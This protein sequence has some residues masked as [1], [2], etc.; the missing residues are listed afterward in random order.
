[1]KRAHR[2]QGRLLA[3]LLPIFLALAAAAPTA[4]EEVVQ[5]APADRADW[6]P[7]NLFGF[8]RPGH[9]Y[10]ERFIRVRTV[11]EGALV[12]LFYIR[13]NFQK[14]YEQAESPVKVL[15]PQRIQAGPR[16][17]VTIRAFH[18]GYRQKEVSI[19][20]ASSQDEVLL[21]L[22]ALPN[23]LVAASHVYLAGRSSMSFLTKEALQ[24]RVQN[25]SDGFS[26]ILAETAKGE[27][28]GETLD[29]VSSPLVGRVEAL[30]LGEDLLV[31]VETRVGS[32]EFDLRSRQ[33]QDE[34]RDLFVYSVEMIPSDGGVEA[35]RQARAAL[36]AIQA[37]E[38]AG[39][40]AR[41]DATLRGNLDPAQLSRA[42]AP[43]GSFTDP[44]LRAAMKRL[45]AVSPG[46]RIEM[47][48]GSKLLGSSSIELAAA[49]SQPGEAKGYLALLRAFVGRVESADHRSD[50]LRGI[51]AP[52]LSAAKFGEA[53][54]AAEDVERV[55]Q[56]G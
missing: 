26:V 21:E 5:L 11:P 27:E 29:Q 20:V 28:A 10:G 24:V 8:L 52:E 33:A 46:G 43:K 23:L 1:M 56:T 41:F 53:L 18:E 4:A 14:R 9:N 22:E 35:V 40:A 55:C 45:G 15:L 3:G 19:R 16:D 49:M 42:L 54:K 47:A 51:I 13:S 12:D 32:D 44:Y 30:Q 39:C 50:T 48:D 25:R 34:L 37:S 36:A 6:S 7:G 38:V 31:Q 2:R 17:A